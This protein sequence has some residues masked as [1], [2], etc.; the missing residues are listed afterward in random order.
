MPMPD[1]DL[2]TP[3]LTDLNAVDLTGQQTVG[4]AETPPIDPPDTEPVDPPDTEFTGSIKWLDVRAIVV[5]AVLESSY[6]YDVIRGIQVALR[7]QGESHYSAFTGVG[8]QNAEVASTLYEYPTVENIP[9]QLGAYID[10]G[11]LEPG[12]QV[13]ARVFLREGDN[14]QEIFSTTV[15]DP[16][17]GE[18]EISIPLTG[19]LVPEGG[20]SQASYDA[21]I[22]SGLPQGITLPD[23]PPKYVPPAV[24]SRP[25]VTA[26]PRPPVSEPQTGSGQFVSID[27]W[28]NNSSIQSTVGARP[29]YGEVC[30]INRLTGLYLC[31]QQIVGYIV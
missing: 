27:D 29:V 18:V 3:V 4:D 14:D 17:Y 28:M 2:T 15:I 5:S 6:E 21:I 9:D 23:P 11:W 1:V 16:D 8:G 7:K 26:S 13:T 12:A 22:R 31:R 19:V 30:E 10:M 24:P 25:P 20:G